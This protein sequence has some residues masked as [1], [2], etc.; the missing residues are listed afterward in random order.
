ML[1]IFRARVVHVLSNSS[2]LFPSTARVHL[3]DECRILN[4][5]ASDLYELPS[6]CSLE[7]FPPELV[8]VFICVTDCHVWF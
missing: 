4:V 2:S 5:K 3:L 1:C 7:S 6:E 8:E